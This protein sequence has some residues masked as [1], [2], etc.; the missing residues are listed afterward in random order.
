MSCH[1]GGLN[2]VYDSDLPHYSVTRFFL[3]FRRYD[4]FA[5]KRYNFYVLFFYSL[6]YVGIFEHVAVL[7]PSIVSFIIGYCAFLLR[8][9]Q[10]N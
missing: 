7:F 1:D 6:F 5:F 10:I 4:A 9:S 2:G 3:F 8:V